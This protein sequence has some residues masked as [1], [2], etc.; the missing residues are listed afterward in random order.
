MNCVRVFTDTNLLVGQIM[1]A[2]IKL[3]KFTGLTANKEYGQV[4]AHV[5]RMRTVM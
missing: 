3:T 4:N 5:H 1:R 2:Q